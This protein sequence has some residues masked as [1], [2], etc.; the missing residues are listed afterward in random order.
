MYS[1]LE[2]AEQIYDRGALSWLYLWERTAQSKPMGLIRLLRYG[3]EGTQ[4]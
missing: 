1:E 3:T 4:I 2:D